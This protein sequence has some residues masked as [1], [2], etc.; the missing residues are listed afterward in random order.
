M[1]MPA[2]TQKLGIIYWNTWY[3]ADPKKQIRH[4]TELEMAMADR[5][6]D[7]TLL[8]L[9]EVSREIPGDRGSRQ[10]L[11]EQLDT[12]GYKT[13][14]EPISTVRD[15]RV[16][17]GLCIATRNIVDIEYLCSTHLRRQRGIASV[18]DRQV[19]G[20]EVE[21]R[22]SPLQVYLAHLSYLSP[23]KKERNGLV[24]RLIQDGPRDGEPVRQIVGGDFN[25]VT[26][27]RIIED[28]EAF[29]M[30]KLTDGSRFSRATVPLGRLSFVGMELDHVLVG[31][32]VRASMQ[33][34]DR[35]PSNHTPLLVEVS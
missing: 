25:T 29:A 33:I 35:G 20:V 8:C 12:A 6:I 21:H 3:R 4:L 24:D 16:Q 1:I 27:R 13:W 7:R 18:K 28:L 14:Y 5:G 23:A 9:S 22:G 11:L 32:G 19:T 15:R 10:G 31:D 17:E 30:T 26:S 34:G 2:E